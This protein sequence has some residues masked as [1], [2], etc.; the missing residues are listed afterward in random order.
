MI[1]KK[2]NFGRNIQKIEDTYGLNHFKLLQYK[3]VLNTYGIDSVSTH[4]WENLICNLFAVSLEWLAF[5]GLYPG[6]SPY[7]SER[8]L[9]LEGKVFQQG[10]KGILPDEYLNTKQRVKNYPEEARANL[11][12]LAIMVLSNLEP[13]KKEEREKEIRLI[14]E[15]KKPIYIIY[16]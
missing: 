10:V 9:Y 1:N 2:C 13:Y 4:V 14:L 7:D 6:N 11:L 3:D 8:L 16:P 5:Y 15:S 12:T